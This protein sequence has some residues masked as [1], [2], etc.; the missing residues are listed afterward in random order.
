MS[1]RKAWKQRPVPQ[2]NKPKSIRMYH[3]RKCGHDFADINDMT[4]RLIAGQ[5]IPGRWCRAC[6]KEWMDNYRKEHLAEFAARQKEYRDR[7]RDRV[8]QSVEVIG[9]ADQPPDATD[10]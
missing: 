5:I 6:K 9:D 10:A 3:C 1:K 8:R 4:H 2:A 7:A